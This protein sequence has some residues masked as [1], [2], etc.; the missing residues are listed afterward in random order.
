MSALD[1]LKRMREER[2]TGKR[3]RRYTDPATGLEYNKINTSYRVS[4]MIWDVDLARTAQVVRDFD[5]NVNIHGEAY[6]ANSHRGL[7]D[8]RKSK[9]FGR[10]R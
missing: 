10:G 7:V 2:A 3:T 6:R 5:E 4:P 1:F 8:F 9:A